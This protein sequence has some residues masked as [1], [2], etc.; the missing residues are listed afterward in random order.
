MSGPSRGSMAKVILSWVAQKL[1]VLL[2]QEPAILK[3]LEEEINSI[4]LELGSLLR[5]PSLLEEF[6]DIAYDIEDVID[7]LTLKSAATRRSRGVHKKLEQIKAKIRDLRRGSVSYAFI[8]AQPI[9]DLNIASTVVSPVIEK[10]TALLAQVSLHSQVRRK[11]R[12]LL[13]EFRLINHF[14][15]LESENLDETGMVWM[16]ELCIISIYAIDVIGFYISRRKQFKRKGTVR[17]VITAFNRLWSQLRFGKELDAINARIEDI[18]ER[19]P[20]NVIR[21]D[22]S[23]GRKGLYSTSW[24]YHNVEDPDF[25]S[26]N[27][28]VREIVAQLLADD[29]SF[30]AISIVGM[31]GIGKTTLAKMVYD[32]DAVVGHFPY[33]AWSCESDDGEEFVKDILEQMDHDKSI[34][35]LWK[36]ENNKSVEEEAEGRGEE[37]W[38]LLNTFL[39]N[40]KYLVV[41]DAIDEAICFEQLER[42]FPNTSNGSKMILITR[43][44]NLLLDP[45]KKG[46]HLTLQLR[47]D[48]E[49][50][51]L[52]THILKVTIPPE[53]L[54][55][56]GDILKTCSGLPLIIKKVA[57]VLSHKDTTIAEWSSVI[58]QLNGDQEFRSHIVYEINKELPLHMKRCLFYF[59]LF[60]P[61]YDIPA[62]R[63][64][65]LWIAEGLV[66]SK[67]AVETPED[68]AEKYLTK[69]IGQCMVQIT[70][71]KLNG[72]VQ[73][74]RLPDP[75]RRQW[76]L[77]AKKAAFF[78]D[79]T[80]EISLRTG[81]IRRLVDHLDGADA[82]F[83]HIHGG[84]NTISG[85]LQPHYQDTLSFLSFD[86][87]E[88][89]IPGEDIG[90]FLHRCI[91]SKGFLFLRV[92]DLEHVFK[93]KLPMALGKLAH[94]RYLGL[95]WTFLEMLPSSI[96]KLQN[97]RTLDLKHTYIRTLPSSIWKLQKLQHLYLSESCWTK[98][99]PQPRLESLQTLQTLWGLFVDEK[100]PVKDGL[101]KL[102]NLKKLGLGCRSVHSRHEA[103]SVQLEAVSDWVLKLKHLQSLRLKSENQDNQPWDLEL[104]PLCSHVNLSSIYLIG[105]LKNQSL[106]SEFPDS[107]TDL[108]LSGSVLTEDPMQKLYKL[109]NLKILRLLAKSYVGKDMHCSLEGFPQLR[110]LK[111]WKL[112]QLEQ[113]NVEVGALP[114]LRDLEIRSCTRLKMLPIGLKQRPF[115]ELKLTN[116]PNQFI[117]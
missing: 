102:V 57:D 82:S 67:Q 19:R 34:T 97:L 85:P 39:K 75:I 31:K 18:S 63:L 114:S 28:D 45:Q 6:R 99:M 68:V 37:L 105:R 24:S 89:S 96:G 98:F 3:G 69:L 10:V 109:P 71:K 104:K 64:I 106:V 56:R 12:R 42:R 86:T 78:Q 90:N 15:D 80:S 77:K 108:T 25:I 40:K 92:L 76:Y 43:Y 32:T 44:P 27:E 13:D 2:I 55:L 94:L 66:D 62:R 4:C 21:H 59:G 20:D 53:L 117:A 1:S 48:N 60:P 72:K 107:L 70:K 22:Q 33:R 88:G 7:N 65:A 51:A 91:S 11:A 113:W 17:R 52:F 8:P 16:E 74:C 41:V 46:I 103:M 38:S 14:Y 9:D 26:F 101:D 30:F 111:L 95:R 54:T 93:P 29:K 110:V 87:R 50:W 81:M 79:H 36:K 49:S 116:M 58:Q 115:L 35:A 100:T 73:A 23:G 83:I 47:D 84:Y 61:N 112:E 5:E